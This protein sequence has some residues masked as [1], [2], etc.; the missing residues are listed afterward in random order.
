MLTYRLA[1]DPKFRDKNQKY[2]KR[3]RIGYLDRLPGFWIADPVPRSE[4]VALAP[5]TV[6]VEPY[7]HLS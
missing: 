1:A 3:G 6:S 2:W 5:A 4:V 7:F